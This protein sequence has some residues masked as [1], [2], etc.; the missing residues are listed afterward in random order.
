MLFSVLA[1]QKHVYMRLVHLEMSH[2]GEN[3]ESQYNAF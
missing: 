3:I 2:F 1:Y